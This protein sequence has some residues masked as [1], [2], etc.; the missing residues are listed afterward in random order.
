M[1]FTEAIDAV[2]A[3]TKRPEKRPEIA[4]RLNRA[5]S[6]FTLKASFKKDLVE[7]STTVDPTSYGQTI[8]LSA[9]SPALVRFRK[10]KYIRPTNQRYYLKFMEPEF[11][12]TPQGNIQPNRYYVAGNSVTFTLSNLTPSLEIGY[13]QYAPIL[14]E[15]SPNNTHW[16]LDLMPWALIDQAAASIFQSIG[17]EQSAKESLASS[18]TLFVT[19]RNDF[20]DQVVLSAS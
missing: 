9:F 8:D 5:L 16:M 2:V 17:D 7:V 3:V 19:A 14:T 13:Y 20:E 11:I 18:G 4:N 6:L 1:N 15:V 12:L 10:F